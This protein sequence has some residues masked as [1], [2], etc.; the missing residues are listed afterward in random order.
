MNLS[1]GPMSICVLIYYRFEEK[2]RVTIERKIK[3]EQ[4]FS[5]S[6]RVVSGI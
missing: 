5:E 6:L 3:A 1:Q 2:L 4:N